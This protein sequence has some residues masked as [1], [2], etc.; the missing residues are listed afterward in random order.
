[1]CSCPMSKLLEIL[2]SVLDNQDCS[3]GVT[4]DHIIWA[5]EE[6]LGKSLEFYATPAEFIK[7]MCDDSPSQYYIIPNLPELIEI[8]KGY[9]VEAEEL[10]RTKFK[11]EPANN[12]RW[13]DVDEDILG[14]VKLLWGKDLS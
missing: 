4:W 9:L 8:A 3:I 2:Q 11:I 7:L 5:T 6:A 13:Q 10:E 1:M 14:E 12:A